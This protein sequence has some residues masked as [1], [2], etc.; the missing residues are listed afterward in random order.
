MDREWRQQEGKRKAD[1]KID[2]TVTWENTAGG[3]VSSFH[4]LWCTHN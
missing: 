2:P 1:L 3:V 4:R